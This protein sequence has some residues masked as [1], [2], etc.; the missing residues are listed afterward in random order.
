MKAGKAVLLVGHGASPSD[1]PRDLA[2]ELRRLEAVKPPPGSREGKRRL[3]LDKKI[4]S[5]PRTARTD[6]YHAGLKAIARALA[7]ALPGREVAFAFNEFCGPTIGEAVERLARHGV[8]EVAV[9]PTMYTRGGVHSEED[10]PVILEGLR[11]RHPGMR[12]RYAWPFPTPHI[13]GFL[14]GQ[15]RRLSKA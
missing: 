4:R 10:I 15:I 9:I 13:A 12:I 7:R 5:W 3:E 6:P 11:R 1:F 14:A 8:A 2:G